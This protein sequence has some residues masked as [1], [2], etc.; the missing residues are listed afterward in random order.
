MKKLLSLGLLFSIVVSSVYAEKFSL[1]KYEN[2][3]HFYS[4][5]ADSAIAVAKKHNLPAAAMLALAGLESGYGSGY[6]AQISGN[7]MSLG[8]FKSDAEL[9]ALYLPYSKS[10]KKI[11]FDPSQIKECSKSDL[12]WKKRAPS[13]KRDY[14]PAPYAGT[15]KNLA[16]LKDNEKLQ[17]KA[18]G[19]C[20]DDFATRWIVTTSN[21]PV[22]SSAKKWLDK[23]VA[24]DGVQTLFSETT[25]VAFINK[26]GGV[27]HSFNYRKTW[28]PKVQYILDRAGLVELVNNMKKGIS[29]E[30]AWSQK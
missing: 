18:Y 26:I 16:L 6:V 7:I 30:K 24:K 11:L 22:F 21:I 15:D 14:R 20:L 1:R 5:I 29:F 2:V 17:M 10:Q 4:E 3:K 19:E 25:N 28:P 13:L 12:S 8:A 9:P 23:K 27:P